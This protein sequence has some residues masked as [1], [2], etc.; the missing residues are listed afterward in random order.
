MDA[1]IARVLNCFIIN[2]MGITATMFISN[3]TQ[4]NNQC[5]LVITF[6]VPE[7]MVCRMIAKMCYAKLLSHV[8]LFEMPRTVAHQAPLSMGILQENELP[9]P[10][11]RDSEDNRVY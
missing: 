2:R 6:I 10:S 7:M 9:C 1:S 3:P 5:E 8:R 11:P 4:V